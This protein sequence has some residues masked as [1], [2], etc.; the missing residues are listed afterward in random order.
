[1]APTSSDMGTLSVWLVW[2]VTVASCLRNPWASAVTLYGP[3]ARL[4]NWKFPAASD[5]VVADTWV[6]SVDRFKAG[7]RDGRPGGVLDDAA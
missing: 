3:G 2:R 1:M 5:V 6:V 4:R 7:V